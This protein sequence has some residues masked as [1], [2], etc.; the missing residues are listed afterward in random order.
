MGSRGGEFFVYLLFYLPLDAPR[1]LD[2]NVGHL[3]EFSFS[4]Q[5]NVRELSIPSFEQTSRSHTPHASKL[6]QLQ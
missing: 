5:F 1:D 3:C 2:T 4:A 6:H